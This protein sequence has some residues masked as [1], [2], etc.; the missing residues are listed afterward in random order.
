MLNDLFGRFVAAATFFVVG[1]HVIGWGMI[2]NGSAYVRNPAWRLL[3]SFFFFEAL[4]VKLLCGVFLAAAVIFLAIRIVPPITALLRPDA[5]GGK[6]HQDTSARQDWAQP[7]HDP[8]D[9]HAAS[10]PPLPSSP[11]TISQAL[12]PEPRAQ[13]TPTR[14]TPTP[15]EL[16]KKAIE[17]ILRGL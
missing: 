1:L 17:Q 2:E 6:R 4:V 14:S 12:T 15:E 16:K 9:R 10:V 5:P 11:A 7:D 8:S 13:P 3:S